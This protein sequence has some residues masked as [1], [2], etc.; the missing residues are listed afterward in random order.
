MELDLMKRVFRIGDIE[1]FE[2]LPSGH[3]AWL[4]AKV[5]NLAAIIFASE[6][7]TEFPSQSHRE[8]E[9]IYVLEGHLEYDD[10]RVADAGEALYNLADISHPGR[11]SGRLLNIMI[12]SE[13]GTSPSSEDSMSK[14][15]RIE[16]METHENSM[17]NDIRSILLITRTASFCITEAMPGTSWM[18]PGHPEKEII[19]LIQGQL[20]YDDGRV[21][22]AGEAIIN[23][24]NI[25]H[26]GKRVGHELARLL[27]IKSPPSSRLLRILGK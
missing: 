4:L 17:A 15:I 22:R 5:N 20:E 27:E 7:L 24:P 26:P 9:F 21:V 10:G 14:V 3:T 11:Y 12:C 19:Y 18:D 2:V 1:P 13:A 25:P 16:D 6:Q 23:L 8:D